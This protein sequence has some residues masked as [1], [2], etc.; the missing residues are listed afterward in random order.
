MFLGK[1]PSDDRAELYI[2]AEG[3]T[4]AGESFAGHI[5]SGA[6][7]AWQTLDMSVTGALRHIFQ[8]AGT[9]LNEWNRKSIA[10]HRVSLGVVC[11]ARRGA[12]AV[13]AQAGP[14]VLFHLSGGQLRVCT[15][16]DEFA[17]PVGSGTAVAPQ[18]S[19]LNLRAGDRLLLVSTA[20]LSDMDQELIGGILGL[21]PD[22]VL[23][24]LYRR[25]QHLRHVTALFLSVEEIPAE[26]VIGS[27]GGEPVIDATP[28]LP[29]AA[30][31]L[32]TA[33]LR[34]VQRAPLTKAISLGTFQPSLFIDDEEG[35]DQLAAARRRITAVHD[36]V[37]HSPAMIPAIVTEIPRPLRRAAGDNELNRLAAE[38]RSH[39]TVLLAAN[40]HAAASG[41]APWRSIPGGVETNVDDRRRQRRKDSFSAGLSREEWA[42]RPLIIGDGTPLAADMAAEIN[43]R[44]LLLGAVAETIA[45]ENAETVTSGGALVRVRSTMPARS[46]RGGALSGRGL[47]APE[48]LPPTW[49]IILVGLAVLLAVVGF[50]TVPRL[51]QNSDGA[52]YTQLIDQ[53][54]QQ[55]STAHAVQD[56]A[57]KRGAL[58]QAQALLLEARDLPGAGSQVTDFLSQLA[59]ELKVLDAV[60]APAA[61]EVLGS[62][63]QFGDKPVAAT[64]LVVGGGTAYVL[65]S[66]SNQVVSLA[67]GGSGTEHAVVYNEDKDARRARPVAMLYVDSTDLGEPSLLVLDASRNLWAV[68]AKLGIRPIV[69]AAAPAQV[70]TDIT[71]FG[72]DLYAL[73]GQAGAV[74]RFTPGDGGYVSP[75]KVLDLAGVSAPKRLMVDLSSGEDIFVTDASGTIHRFAG[76]LSL[77]LSEGGIDKKLASAEAPLTVGKTGELWM[78]D[79][80]NNRIVVLRR[81]GAFDRQ[82]QHKD[83][84]GLSAFTIQNG[85][86]YIFSSGKL[87]RVTF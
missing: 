14:S 49:A 20:A 22:R 12:Q 75:V 40:A 74:Y 65:D 73:D 59:A 13:V 16:E 57:E 38:R 70:V 1:G 17:T 46:R 27:V 51:L 8:D 53:A 55:L 29:P 30:A 42:P 25:V 41:R 31:P 85:A 45:T 4:P 66:A 72:R 19:R 77:V 3:T 37:R 78:L 79:A 5:V 9:S 18:F 60:R 10:Q 21:E 84:Q 71:M 68:S 82:Y 26:R 36:R 7:Q 15:A 44:P 47:I 62:L 50:L 52:R 63:E 32:L 86:A 83:F 28:H 69:F 43:A 76:Q 54:N 6:G 56:P 2:L 64:R 35:G 80:P 61:V 67:L 24:N 39:A 87:R 11:F 81:D 33:P 58:V 48:K 34:A 23:A